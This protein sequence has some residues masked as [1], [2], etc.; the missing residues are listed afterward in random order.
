M[1]YIARARTRTMWVGGEKGK[2]RIK[3]DFVYS[4]DW[5]VSAI[6][7]KS[8]QACFSIWVNFLNLGCL[9]KLKNPTLRWIV[10]SLAGWN[11]FLRP[12]R[13]IFF[14]EFAQ[15]AKI[16]K[17][18]L[19]EICRGSWGFEIFIWNLLFQTR[20]T[21]SFCLFEKSLSYMKGGPPSNQHTPPTEKSF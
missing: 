10:S 14:I 7:A 15:L 20:K 19:W 12:R 18:H 11:E 4:C 5:W 6:L 21:S 8:Y 13:Y 16:C 17:C 3:Q 2:N 9:F 1:R